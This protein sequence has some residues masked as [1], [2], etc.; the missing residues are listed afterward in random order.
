MF[1]QIIVP[2]DGSEDA[3]AAVGPA[4]AMAQRVGAP[5]HILALAHNDRER[6][7]LEATVLEQ[8]GSTGDVVR[9]VDVAPIERSVAE[10][11]SRLAARHAPSLV[12]MSTHGRGRS[13]AVLGSVA[14]DVLA[15]TDQPVMLVGPTMIRGRFRTHGPAVVA[16]TGEDDRSVLDLTTS[17]TVETDVE[18]VVAHVLAPTAARQLDAAHLG[19]TG[20]DFPMDS[21]VAERAAHELER[22]TDRTAVDFDVY[23]DEHPAKAITEQA[24]TRRASLVVM[25][26]HARH[27]LDRLSHG[28]VTADVVREA[29]CPVLVVGLKP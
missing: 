15:A 24:I 20:S 5:I 4:T 27:G 16:V 12:V 21:V 22:S 23:Y 9:V 10:D 19:P 28:S 14:N 13:A 26:T 17:L 8:V 7:A 3:A 1:Q 18:P 2:L 29:P 25:A 6:S 11:I